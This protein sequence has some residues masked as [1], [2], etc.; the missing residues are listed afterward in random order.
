MR[1][2]RSI[3]I[4]ASGAQQALVAGVTGQIVRVLGFMV[5]AVAGSASAV[6][7]SASTSISGTLNLAAG[8]PATAMAP[9]VRDGDAE[10][11]R[12]VAGEALNI[13]AVGNV[14]GF[15]VV[16]VVSQTP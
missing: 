13:T 15:C 4:A 10:L 12:T 3:V 8:T 16:E 7:Q 2:R 14:G 9:V 6:F 11:F 5:T 1:Q